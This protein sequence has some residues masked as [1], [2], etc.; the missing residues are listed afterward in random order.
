MFICLRRAPLR[1]GSFVRPKYSLFFLCSSK[2]RTK[3]RAPE[4]KNSAFLSACYA[5]L[6][7]A[8]KKSEFL[9]VSGLPLA[10]L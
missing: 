6:N 9:A 7:G 5:S 3:E 1:S 4:T 2:E 10:P 8:T